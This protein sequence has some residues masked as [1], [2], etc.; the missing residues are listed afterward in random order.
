MA[1][2]KLWDK[3]EDI[4]TLGRDPK[5]GRQHWSAQE[6]METFAAW[7]LL[8]SARPVVGGG[9]VNGMFF[10]DL[11]NLKAAAERRGAS[12][13]PDLGDEELLQAIEA[14]EDQQN[15]ALPAPA[16]ADVQASL[17][18]LDELRA[19]EDSER[20]HSQ[21]ETVAY[22]PLQARYANYYAQGLWTKR[23]I[24]LAVRKGRLTAEQFR[25]ITGEAYDPALAAEVDAH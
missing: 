4:Y 2:Y 18:A 14:F 9:L 13:S 22:D 15:S 11:S 5:T 21:G 23:Y 10:D 17:A 6:Y 8:P 24:A 7:A 12:F 19:L 20:K 1:R 3:Q 16:A 25:D